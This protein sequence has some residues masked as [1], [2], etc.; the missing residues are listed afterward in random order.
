MK[1]SLLVYVVALLAGAA[2]ACAQQPP[3]HAQKLPLYK[4]FPEPDQDG[5]RTR[6]IYT[7]SYHLDRIYKSMEGPVGTQWFNFHDGGEPRLVWL[8]GYRVEVVG[9]DG[10]SKV[11]QE[12]VCHNILQFHNDAHREIFQR[13]DMFRNTQFDWVTR[14]FTLSQGQ[15]T[16]RFPNGF[17]VPIMSTESL[18][19]TSQ[20]LNLNEEDIDL[21]IRHKV[22][23]DFILDKDLK[24]P[25]KPLMPYTASSLVLVD[26]TNEVYTVEQA[27][28]IQDHAGCSPG[29]NATQSTLDLLVEGPN[30]VVSA[31]WLVEPGREERRTLVTKYLNLPFDTTVH[32]IAVHL[33]PFAESLSFRDV[34]AKKTLFTANAKGQ[35]SPPVLLQAKIGLDRIDSY[36]SEEGIP[37]YKDHEYELVSVY[38]NTSGVDQDA[39]AV[40]VLYILDQE[41]SK[42]RGI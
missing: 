33:H 26:G 41:Y 3:A 2:C 22:S 29:L 31:H 6:E 38:D 11:P 9:G 30:R 27:A 4:G 12:Y 35:D 25:L 13:P 5:I 37:V 7:P 36:S 40:M 32:C 42:P 20:V 15:Y 21:A 34:T 23:I 18:S 14:V 24:K 17:G 28:E 19:M 8:V 39:M 1:R 10:Q 16:T